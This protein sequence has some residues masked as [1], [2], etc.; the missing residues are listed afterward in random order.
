MATSHSPKYQRKQEARQKAAQM[1]L[2]AE[3]AQRRRRVAIASGAVVAL[4]AV[5]LTVGL[6]IRSATSG[7]GV[8]ATAPSGASTTGAITVGKDNAP[9]T[10]DLYLDY[11]CP[12]CKAFED[13]NATMLASMQQEG[14]IKVAYHPIAILDRMSSGTN[15]STRAAN[16]AMCVA[17]QAPGAF[18]TF[19]HQLFVNQPAEGAEGLGDEEL[20]TIAT[21]AGA[22][23][24]TRA[25]I[26][27]Q[28]F[29]T[30]VGQVTDLA[31]EAGLPGTP[32]VKV[33]GTVLENPTSEALQ[34]AVQQ[35]LL[36]VGG[37]RPSGTESPTESP[38]APPTS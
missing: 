17:D 36:E 6:V 27:D 2:E 14:A 11:Q 28:Q 26:E 38:T 15:Y 32:W 33:D 23:A 8:T 30:Y 19:T 3:R 34:A 1:R 16:A 7:S 18:E 20:V 29:K 25:C 4:L 5:V 21:A 24:Q 10:V 35:A 37:M 9:V 13:A 31:R 12:A 22:P